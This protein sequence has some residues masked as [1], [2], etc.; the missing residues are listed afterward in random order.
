MKQFIFVNAL[1]LLIASP[2]A[3]QTGAVAPQ[4]DQHRARVEHLL[5]YVPQH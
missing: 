1:L 4:A 2:A 5:R 3:M